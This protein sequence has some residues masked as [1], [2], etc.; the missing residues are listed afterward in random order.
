MNKREILQKQFSNEII[1]NNYT[2]IFLLSPRFGKTKVVIDAINGLYSWNVL[3]STPREDI[4]KAWLSEFIKWDLDFT[5]TVIC[6][7]SLLKQKG[8]DI[9]LL[10]IDECHLLSDNQ[11]NNIKILKPKRLL[12]LTGTLG[13]GRLTKLKTLLKTDMCVSYTI[14]D[15]I[16]DNI[17]SDYEI[18]IIK[19]D[20]TPVERNIYNKL[21]AN[22]EWCRQQALINN[23]SF[24]RA[25]MNAARRRMYY[26]YNTQSK[27]LAV[28]EFIKD[29]ER[30]LIFS[31]TI[32]TAEIICEH[33]YHS[34]SS[35]YNNNLELFKD[36]KI[37]KLAVCR[38]SDCGI[39]FPNLKVGIIHQV[40]S[41]EEIFLQ[42]SLRC[43]NLEGDKIAKLYIF[44]CKD[45][46]DEKWL[47][48]CLKDINKDKIKYL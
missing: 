1:K 4:N 5:P 37:N 19:V 26:I 12:L 9:D 34:K 23:T 35:K 6:N 48:D 33:S 45:T 3:I 30:C 39:T 40:Q 31:S 7:N 27:V 21:T 32:K 28:K 44:V 11:I 36:N 47:E 24:I 15:A 13:Q 38:M 22:Y 14:D 2:G 46:I 25:K 29:Y 10:V 41:G 17:I 42:R 18:N 16:R 20:L 8:K 43:C